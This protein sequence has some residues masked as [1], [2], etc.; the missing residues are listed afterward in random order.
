MIKKIIA[1]LLCLSVFAVAPAV[2]AEETTVAETPAFNIAMLRSGLAAFSGLKPEADFSAEDKLFI[3]TVNADK[4][5]VE[6]VQ[7]LLEDNFL[8]IPDYIDIKTVEL[9]SDIMVRFNPDISITASRISPVTNKTH[10]VLTISPYEDGFIRPSEKFSTIGMED[11]IFTIRY[12]N[13]REYNN[14]DIDVFE[15]GATVTE[16]RYIFH[17]NGDSYEMTVAFVK[18]SD[19]DWK[20]FGLQALPLLDGFVEFGG[21]LYYHKNGD[22][23]HGWYKIS[24]KDYY[25]YRWDGHAATGVN[26]IDGIAYRFD[27]D[28]VYKGRYTGE[29]EHDGFFAGSYKNG[30]N[31]GDVYKPG[32]SNLYYTSKTI[33]TD[34]KTPEAFMELLRNLYNPESFYATHGQMKQINDM[35]LVAY[36]DFLNIANYQKYDDVESYIL[37]GLITKDT[38]ILNMSKIILYTG[39][40]VYEI[41]VLSDDTFQIYWNQN[42]L[43]FDLSGI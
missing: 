41:T 30:V 28:C 1:L 20:N 9:L 15:T 35:I 33:A 21:K 29:F 25:F 34:I 27:D 43:P 2:S 18:Q 8:L 11:D 24:G 38:A 17:T 26:V 5:S 19:S 37:E 10:A 6:A 14:T 40:N 7:K 31:E 23:L 39:G 16:N 4:R 13:V 36:I 3:K 32:N 42:Q 12:Y 22:Y